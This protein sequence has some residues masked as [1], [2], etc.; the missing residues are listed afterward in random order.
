MCVCDWWCHPDVWCHRGGVRGSG[1]NHTSSLLYTKQ[2]SD[3]WPLTWAGISADLCLCCWL[4][5][6]M[7]NSWFT[8][9]LTSL[10][11]VSVETRIIS[12]PLE[13]SQQV[14]RVVTS[15][16][17]WSEAEAEGSR[18]NVDSSS[19]TRRTSWSWVTP[20][21]YSFGNISENISY[22]SEK[23]ENKTKN[24]EWSATR[25][26]CSVQLEAGIWLCES[27]AGQTTPSSACWC[28]LVV[29]TAQMEQQGAV[30]SRR[31]S[32]AR[33]DSEAHEP[34][35]LQWEDAAAHRET[36]PGTGTRTRTRTRIKTRTRTRTRI[37]I[38]IRTRL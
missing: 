35:A 38:R 34:W 10:P 24:G 26:Q 12:T 2:I 3:L 21:F 19:I 23:S 17:T 27:I 8:W 36:P 29:S 25:G 9:F 31:R 13:K 5:T 37:R 7:G 11:S 4:M 6:L 20:L 16:V 33:R 15:C 28:Q 30:L 22:I 14:H 1:P 18:G 32:N